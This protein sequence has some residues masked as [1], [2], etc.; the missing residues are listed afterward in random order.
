MRKY[1]IKYYLLLLGLFFVVGNGIIFGMSK[2]TGTTACHNNN[3]D[4]ID[5]S[6]YPKGHRYTCQLNGDELG[7]KIN[8]DTN[9]IM[10]GYCQRESNSINSK[11]PE[12]GCPNGFYCHICECAEGMK[13]DANGRCCE[14][15]NI[16]KDGICCKDGKI[17]NSDG[18]CAEKPVETVSEE[19]QPGGGLGGTENQGENQENN[20]NKCPPELQDSKGN[21][22]KKMYYDLE[23]KKEV[24]C[25]GILL[26][27]NVPFIGQCIVYRKADEPQPEA[28]LVVDETNAFPVLMGGLSKIL[29]S[30]ILLSSFLGLL[31]AGVMISASGSSEDG[32]KHGRKIIGNIVSALAIL[33]ASGVILRLI[34]PNFFG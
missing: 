8:I 32:A 29:V 5:R 30:I 2:P 19:E 24:C 13:T 28:G 34:N 20:E 21:C 14:D 12:N 31:V 23:L 1:R 17:P 7:Q 4:P 3:N 25:E 22:C 10:G 9:K 16:G 18:I 27:T 33:G 26:N 11:H 15:G 6:I